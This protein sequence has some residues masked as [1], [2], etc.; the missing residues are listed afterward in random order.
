MSDTCPAKCLIHDT[1]C[2]IVL[3]I[4]MPGFATAQDEDDHEHNCMPVKDVMGHLMLMHRWGPGGH[5]YTRLDPAQGVI[6]SITEKQFESAV[7]Q[8]RHGFDD[9]EKER[10]KALLQQLRKHL[11][12]H[13]APKGNMTKVWLDRKMDEA[14]KQD[15]WGLRSLVDW[16]E[17][18]NKD[19][20]PKPFM[21]EAVKKTWREKS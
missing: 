1:P 16:W 11:R 19:L 3:G 13:V 21:R 7:R 9:V 2:G 18:R 17:K 14:K 5:R 6:T 10:A 12:P 20:V 15:L 8:A 4:H